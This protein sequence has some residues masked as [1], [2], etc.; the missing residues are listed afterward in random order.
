MR[1][2]FI[3]ISWHQALQPNDMTRQKLRAALEDNSIQLLDDSFESSKCSVSFH[4]TLRTANITSDRSP[5][6]GDGPIYAISDFI[7]HVPDQWK[8]TG[9]VFIPLYQREALMMEFNSIR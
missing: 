1:A 6:L 9:G 3:Q 8:T 7:A 2:K 5:D 4:R